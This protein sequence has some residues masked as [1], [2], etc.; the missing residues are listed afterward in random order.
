MASLLQL[1]RPA[2]RYRWG[3]CALLFAVIT[4]NYIDRQIIG[5]LKPV[6]EEDMGWSEVDYG[7]IVTAFQASY[8]IGLLVVGRWQ[9]KLG[10]IRQKLAEAAHLGGLLNVIGLGMQLLARLGQQRRQIEAWRKCAR[11]A[12]QKA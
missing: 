9:Q 3:I 12:E 7:N 8:G 11:H 4:V 1:A 6:I 2:G 10:P 5:V